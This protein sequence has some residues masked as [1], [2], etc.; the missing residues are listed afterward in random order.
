MKRNG[1]R[2]FLYA[3]LP[4]VGLLVLFGAWYV[5][6][7]LA[8][9]S[10]LNFNHAFHDKTVGVGCDLCH[11]VS[12]GNARFMSF[13][14]HDTCSAFHA[15]ALDEASAQKNCELCHNLPG[16]QTHVRKDA[17]L[18]PLV[19]FDHARHAGSGVSCDACHP[20]LDKDVLVGD[21]MLPQMEPTCI[22]CHE[23]KKVADVKD[24]STCHLEGW[25]KTAPPSHDTGWKS[26][27]AEGLSK[28]T[29][30]SRCQVCHTAKLGNS[31]TTC[32][33]RTGPKAAKTQ[34]CALC[35][36][37]GFD[38]RRPADHT[39]LWIQAHGRNLPQSRIEASC[40]RCH[41][42]QKGNDCLSCHKRKAPK[43]HTVA[44]TMKSHGSRAKLD[45]QRCSVCHDQSECVSCH[46]TNPPSSHTGLWGSPNDRHCINC[47]VEGDNY[48]SGAVGSNCSFCHQGADVLAA[49]KSLPR[50][51][52]HPVDSCTNCHRLSGGAPNTNIR[53]PYPAISADIRCLSCH[54]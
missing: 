1:K 16:Y 23:Q 13:P 49:H 33:H 6:A 48:A 9:R 54:Q 5:Y 28:E 43:D 44:W 39:P 11:S 41:T 47:H 24:C 32:H 15:D 22:R 18:S 2:I 40:L 36:G 38:T 20:V 27:H 19:R 26:L 42:A 17:V 53:H 14:G 52:G 8:S 12:P 25:Q 45:R 34:N 30:D 35:H 21:E 10:G 29:I 7:E 31:C 51:G 3:G 50:P 46:T 4:L 37:K